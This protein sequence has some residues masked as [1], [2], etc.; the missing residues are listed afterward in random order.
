MLES[1]ERFSNEDRIRLANQLL[2]DVSSADLAAES[3]EMSH[4]PAWKLKG[5]RALP[6][7]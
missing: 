7:A 4:V 3:E 2:F 1:V 6:D 5:Y